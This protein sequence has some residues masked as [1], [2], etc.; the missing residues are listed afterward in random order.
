M[1]PLEP[2]LFQLQLDFIRI[3]D[4]HFNFGEQKKVQTYTLV[5]ESY[6]VAFCLKLTMSGALE[7]EW[8]D[9]GAIKIGSDEEYH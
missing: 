1:A 8:L 4:F 6:L 2:R 9:D 3:L 7:D 5:F